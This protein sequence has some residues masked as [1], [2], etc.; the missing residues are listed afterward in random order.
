M[1]RFD[2]ADILITG[3]A[4]GMGRLLARRCLT[5]GARRVVLWDV[6]RAALD[7]TAN[8]LRDGGGTVETAVVDLRSADG[9]D[10]AAQ[11]LIAAA[12]APGILFN[13]AGVVVGKPFDGH[14]RADIETTIQVNTI[15]PMLVTRAFLSVLI[16]RRAGHVVNIASA[17]ALTPNPNMSVYAAS[18]WALLGWSESLRLELAAA[19]CGVRVTTVCPSYVDTGMFAGVRAPLLT[20]ILR[21]E[22]VV[23]RIVRAVRQDRILVRVPAV[24]HLLPALRGL[25]PVR[26]F[27]RLIG[28]GCRVYGSMDGFTGRPGRS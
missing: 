5:E 16:E 24:V 11:R 1:S 21:P 18:K 15:A 25:L 12:T 9:I 20:P 28:R 7:D 19:R 27:D 13:N 4:R 6:D 8:E 22:A 14:S 26:W 23:D 17:A 3:G 2:Q 10:S